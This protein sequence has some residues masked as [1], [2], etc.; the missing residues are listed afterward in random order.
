MQHDRWKCG[1]G[2]Q[3]PALISG[4]DFDHAIEFGGNGQVLDH[5]AGA[6][7]AIADDF[8]AVCLALG[9]ATEAASSSTSG[10][11]CALDEV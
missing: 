5:F 8:G 10:T 11:I 4:D 2:Q 6:L 9:A 3:R 7:V 1:A